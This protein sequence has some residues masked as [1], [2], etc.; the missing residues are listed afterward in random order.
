MKFVIE[1]Y[2]SYQEKNVCNNITKIIV[3]YKHCHCLR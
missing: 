2:D 3:L 1:K